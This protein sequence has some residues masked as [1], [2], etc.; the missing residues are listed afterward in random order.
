MADKGEN[1]PE[2]LNNSI[3]GEVGEE[4]SLNGSHSESEM[5]AKKRRTQTPS[6][7]PTAMPFM[8]AGMLWP[9]SPSVCWC[10][11]LFVKLSFSFLPSLFS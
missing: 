9:L 8:V 5:E 10:E 2:S 7:N 6:P 11:L 1:S 3:D 4:N